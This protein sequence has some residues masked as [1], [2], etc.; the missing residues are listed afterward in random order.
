[1]G[2]AIL[3][4]LEHLRGLFSASS[5]RLFCWTLEPV[6]WRLSRGEY[7]SLHVSRGWQS[8]NGLMGVCFS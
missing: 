1:M 3:I 8:L 5:I 7:T 4:L 2:G 6:L